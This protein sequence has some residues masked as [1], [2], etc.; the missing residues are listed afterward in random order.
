MTIVALRGNGRQ[1]WQWA[2]G[3]A[4]GNGRCP[5]CIEPVVNVKPKYLTAADH[6]GS[7]WAQ[8]DAS[9]GSNTVYLSVCTGH[10]R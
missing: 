1:A 3:V 2:T 4:M 5:V 10:I 6:S 8:F 7:A 9:Y